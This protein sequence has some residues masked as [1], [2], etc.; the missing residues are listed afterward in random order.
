MSLELFSVVLFLAAVAA[1]L[2]GALVGIGGGLLIVPLLT[3]VCG[4]DIRLAIGASI[5]S[6]IATSSGAAAA[7]VR[8]HLT[9]I[10]VGMFLEL[11]TTIGAISGAFLTSL[12]SPG[13]LSVIFGIV[14]FISA[15]P[16]LFKLGEELPG[17]VKNDRWAKW[18]HLSSSYPD[19]R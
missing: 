7:Y 3:L 14:L 15:A 8:D 16:L 10:R 2:L 12:L 11:G 18:L 9:N 4:F 5:V 1:G 19:H 17:G 6:V 13:L